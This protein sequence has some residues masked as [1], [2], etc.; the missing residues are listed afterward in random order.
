MEKQLKEALDLFV[1]EQY[2]DSKEILENVIKEAK[3]NFIN[4]KLDGE[5]KDE[6]C[7]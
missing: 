6:D 7:D 1:S 2:T 4:K 5:E 3:E